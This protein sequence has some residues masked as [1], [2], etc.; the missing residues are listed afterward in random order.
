MTD[1]LQYNHCS[2]SPF[3]FITHAAYAALATPYDRGAQ[4]YGA[5]RDGA[6]W[7]GALWDGALWDGALWDGA[8][9][10]SPLLKRKELR[11]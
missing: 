3:G 7:D 5:R 9:R 1:Y 10:D 4:Q 11:K 2:C 6:L 8:R